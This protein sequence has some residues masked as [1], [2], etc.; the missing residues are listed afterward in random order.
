MSTGVNPSDADSSRTGSSTSVTSLDGV[1]ATRWSDL[2]PW[3]MIFRALPIACSPTIIIFALIA[4][5]LCPVGFLIGERIFI[6]SE[7]RILAGVTDEELATNRSTYKPVFPTTT[8]DWSGVRVFGHQ[9][10]GLDL[11]FFH[12]VKPAGQML[13]IDAGARWFSYNALGWLWAILVWSFFGTCICRVAVMRFSRNESIGLDDAFEYA[14]WKFPATF[15]GIMLPL[16]G[17]LLL[18]IPLALM[19]LIIKLDIGMVLMGA[20]WIF[21]LLMGLLITLLLFG[22]FFSWPLIPASV[23]AEGQDSFDA[24]SRTFAYTY[25]RPVHYLFYMVVALIFSG[26]VYFL[27]SQF[28]S[29]VIHSTDWAVSFGANI[30]AS[31]RIGAMEVG[32]DVPEASGALVLG[33]N[34]I[35]FWRGFAKTVGA[36]FFQG[37]F[38]CVASAI[39]LLLRKDMDRIE[40]DEVILFDPLDADDL[41]ELTVDSDGIPQLDQTSSTFGQAQ[42]SEK[43][44]KTSDDDK[45]D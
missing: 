15:S 25:R 1:A 43:P 9:L 37:F 35:R 29:G 5:V 16:F 2:C 36:A 42:A 41:P 28:T 45:T 33:R 18:L 3:F 30:G 12:Q 21:A 19:G 26:V 40:Y 7:V 34:L 27:V 10:N 38:W 4:S 24:M 39:Y 6:D 8:P 44:D 17:V 11:V 14:I 22:L 20:V 31:D 13:R 23:S 32:D